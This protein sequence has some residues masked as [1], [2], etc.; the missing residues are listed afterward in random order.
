MYKGVFT[1]LITPFNRDG[2][3]DAEALKDFVEFQIAGGV[4][5]LV[6]V[7]TTGE[8]PTV[9]HDEN[10]TVVQIVVEQAKKRV[11]VIAGTGSN[12][13]AEAI[14]MTVRA[15][16]IG[17]DATL[18]VTPYYNKPSQEG[19]YRHFTAIADAA[20]LPMIIYNI[21]GRTAK[22]IENDTMLRLAAHPKIVAVKEASGDLAQ[23]MDLRRRKP[24]DFDILSGDDNLGLPIIA[25]GGTGIISVASN[26]I[27]AKM[28]KLVRLCLEGKMEEAREL[29]YELLPFFK[30]LFIE[31]NPIPVKYAAS[32]LGKCA[33]IYRLPM[34]EMDETKKAAM[35]KALQDLKLL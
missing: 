25:L 10:V 31:T 32:L 1:A 30:T 13:T 15:K 21:A 16:E 22:N 20:G 12:S 7:G 34:C 35:K 5:G 14:A 4:S 9:S 24:A 23:V 11:P 26:I 28:E 33:P 19:I 6:P 18:Q 3:V 2:S 8:S 27:P 29:H 17:A